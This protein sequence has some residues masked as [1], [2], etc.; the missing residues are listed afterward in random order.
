MAADPTAKVPKGQRLP[1]EKHDIGHVA[2]TLEETGVINTLAIRPE[3]RISLKL[4]D[5]EDMF[6]DPPA[7]KKGRMARLQVLGLFY[8]P[9]GHSQAEP[10]FDRAGGG[11][12]YYTD[13]FPGATD[14][15][16]YI[17]RLLSSWVVA[18]GQLPSAA[19]EGAT[20]AAENFAKIHLPGGFCF[21]DSWA[22]TTENVNADDDGAGVNRYPAGWLNDMYARETKYYDDNPALGKIPLVA[23]VEKRNTATLDWVPVKDAEVHFQLLAPY[24]LPAFDQDQ[25]VNLQVNRPPIRDST[26]GDG[27]TH[28]E[29]ANGSGPR[30]THDEAMQKNAGHPT[31]LPADD[32]Q[33]D[34]CPEK[35]GGKAEPAAPKS[36]A[37]G[38]AV[39]DVIFSATSRKGFNTKEARTKHEAFP[40]AQK[41][42]PSGTDHVHAVMAKTNK[43]GQAGVIFMPSRCGG[44][45][46]RIRAYL[47]KIGSFKSNGTGSAAVRVDTGTLVVWRSVR[48][49]RYVRQDCT[50]IA[51]A[52]LDDVNSILATAWTAD[53]Y[54][55]K[56]NVTKKRPAPAAGYQNVGMPQAD[57]GNQNLEVGLVGS[58]FDRFKSQFAKAFIEI[59]VD[60]GAQLPE[61]LAAAEWNRCRNT[62]KA[63]GQA[64]LTAG[65]NFNLDKL[66]FMEAGAPAITVSEAGALIPTRFTQTYNNLLTPAEAAQRYDTT[67]ANNQA[68]LDRVLNAMAMGFMKELTA[69]GAQPGLTLVSAPNFTT[70]Q[71]DGFAGWSGVAIQFRGAY[72]LGGQAAF[73]EKVRRYDATKPEINS[74]NFTGLACH[75]LG[76]CLFRSHAPGE[77]VAGGAAGGILA[78]M[79]DDLSR[80]IC[81]MAYKTSESQ[82]CAGCLFGMR[83]WKIPLAP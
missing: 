40:L 51:Q 54:L 57:F 38:T 65:V 35:W 37:A 46:Y 82:F 50:G 59:E 26:I 77:D 68:A 34:N 30:Q 41:V 42:A 62:A 83:G 15:D 9:L 28:P 25:D 45:S 20:P 56:V 70:L 58:D 10:A 13:K 63:S 12:D 47:G 60:P 2:P 48:V 71:L 53:E 73:P 22:G 31:A 44:D 81:V 33:R 21:T 27:G 43:D 29:H 36:T 49:S 4:G 80:T 72:C 5:F 16:E 8:F 32:P 75:E 69:Q 39:A 55:S 14:P 11:W 52:L 61:T 23:T 74:Y 67:T 3:Y 6:E 79:H 1:T 7:D 66:M 78:N 19:E 24:P 18:D 17:Q 64:L 76:H